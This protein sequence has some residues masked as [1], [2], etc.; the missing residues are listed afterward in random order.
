MVQRL[1]I[2]KYLL[3]LDKVDSFLKL[4]NFLFIAVFFELCLVSDQHALQ[5]EDS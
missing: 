3:A 4:I 5:M 2:E 1:D